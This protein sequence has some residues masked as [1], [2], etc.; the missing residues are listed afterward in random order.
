MVGSAATFV[1]PKAAPSTG[2]SSYNHNLSPLAIELTS[3]KIFGSLQLI[4]TDLPSSGINGSELVREKSPNFGCKPLL[5][6]TDHQRITSNKISGNSARYPAQDRNRE[7][8][9]YDELVES[10]IWPANR[11]TVLQMKRLRA[12]SNMLGRSVNQLLAD[13]VECFSNLIMD[14]LEAT[15]KEE[16]R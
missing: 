12:I 14:E 5:T 2:Q 4:A 3:P 10:E 1:A 8:E 7:F 11:I 13:A 6:Q 16:S 9:P 15:F